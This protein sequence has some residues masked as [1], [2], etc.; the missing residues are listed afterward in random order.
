MPIEVPPTM[1]ESRREA[2]AADAERYL[3]MRGVPWDEVQKSRQ[4]IRDDAASA[5]EKKAR[6]SIILEAIAKREG[7]AVGEEELAAEIGRI[8]AANKMDPA[9]V[10]RRLVRNERIEG[11]RASLREEKALD[12]VVE[13]A[14]VR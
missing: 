3:V 11:L 13:R 1:L 10:R 12:F 14:R 7:I 2:I 5:A 6:A 8:A 9:E 4:N